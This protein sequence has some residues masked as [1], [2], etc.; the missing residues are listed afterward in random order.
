MSSLYIVEINPLSF[1]LFAKFLPFH[2]LSFYFVYTFIFYTKYF[3][4]SQVPCIYFCFYFHYSR[5]WI[6]KDIAAMY[7]KECLTYVFLQGF[8][9]IQILFRSLIHFEFIFVYDVRGCS[10]FIPLH[11]AVQFSQ[12]H[13]LKTP[14]MSFLHC[15]VH[16][17]F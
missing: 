10:N 16:L 6:Q 2:R 3:K 8:Y 7:V 5:R 17:P 15:I 13:L 12:H 4:F 9:S 1:A 11:L 14:L